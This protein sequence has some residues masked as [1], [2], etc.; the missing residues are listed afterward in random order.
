[1]S[2]NFSSCK[3]RKPLPGA[4]KKVEGPKMKNQEQHRPAGATFTRSKA[5]ARG[6]E[7]LAEDEES[8]TT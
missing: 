3:D 7:E 4:E 6:R 5:T 2:S 1:M 8:R